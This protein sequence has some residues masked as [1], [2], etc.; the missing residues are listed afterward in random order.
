MML[1]IS[2]LK[3][4]YFLPHVALGH[5]VHRRNRNL[6]NT[7]SIDHTHLPRRKSK[8]RKKGDVGNSNG[9]SMLTGT[10]EVCSY[11]FG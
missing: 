2:E 1:V 3:Y 11:L 5:R 9:E 10:A 8:L 6:T 7:L 4:E